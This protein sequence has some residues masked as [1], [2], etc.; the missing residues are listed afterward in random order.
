MPKLEK[1]IRTCIVCR[2]KLSKENLIRLQCKD[3][4]LIS[5]DGIGRSFYICKEC[6]EKTLLDEETKKIEKALFKQCKKKDEYLVQLKEII[7][8]VR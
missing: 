7:T 8:H 2:S 6:Q 1:P 5:F 4:K 3:Y